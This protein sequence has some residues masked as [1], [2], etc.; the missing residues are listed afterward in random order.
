MLRAGQNCGIDT[1]LGNNLFLIQVLWAKHLKMKA[2]WKFSWNNTKCL[3]EI[4]E[5]TSKSYQER[6][7]LQSAVLS[8]TPKHVGSSLTVPQSS[9]FQPFSSHGTHKLITK[10][11]RHTKNIFLT[12][13]KGIILIY[14][15]RT[16]VVV[17]A[18]VIFHLTI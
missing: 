5:L 10:I 17:L 4:S 9:D 3:H 14:S 1:A 16:A 6:C 2:Y 7:C 18:A 15:H 8:L 11:L 13:K 12:K